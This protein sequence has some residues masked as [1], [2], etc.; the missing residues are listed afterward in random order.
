MCIH[1]EEPS[2]INIEEPSTVMD[3]EQIIIHYS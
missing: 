2:A 1:I 3:L